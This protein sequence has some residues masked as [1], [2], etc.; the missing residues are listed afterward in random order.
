MTKLT[1][2]AKAFSGALAQTSVAAL[3]DKHGSASLRALQLRYS[4][5]GLTVVG[6]DTFRLHIAKL[7]A[8]G[9]SSGEA[10]L[11]ALEIEAVSKA[12]KQAARYGRSISLSF[13]IEALLIDGKRVASIDTRAQYPNWEKVLPRTKKDGM[14]LEIERKA[15][16]S[17]LEKLT[18]LAKDHDNNAVFMVADSDGSLRLGVDTIGG[19]L[20][21]PVEGLATI[22]SGAPFSFGL[23]ALFL[24]EALQAFTEARWKGHIIKA[25]SPLHVKENGFEVVLMPLQT[26]VPELPQRNVPASATRFVP[27]DKAQAP[28]VEAPTT[29]PNVPEPK[30]ETPRTVPAPRV[31]IDAITPT[32]APKSEPVAAPAR[33]AARHESRADLEEWARDY[34]SSLVGQHPD[35]WSALKRS[36]DYQITLIGSVPASQW[37]TRAKLAFDAKVRDKVTA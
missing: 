35:A 22:K 37:K 23:N 7:D 8:S 5:T 1:V 6:T 33:T 30:P 10:L 12:L 2:S 27:K 32:E 26:K 9:S 28:K 24:R 31:D 20:F 3:K 29:A 34:I 15:F 4:T 14:G 36:F 21:L 25:L 13:D 11:P 18:P 17:T 16:L 19:S